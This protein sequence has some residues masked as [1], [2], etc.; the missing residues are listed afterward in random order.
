MRNILLLLSL[1]IF[2][3]S[4]NTSNEAESPVN[5]V[6]PFIGTG[7][8]GH[9]YPGASLPFGM[10]QLS[11][12][13]RL[14]GW[15]GCSAYHY[16]DSIVYG[17]SH[18]H[19]SGTGIP[20]YGDVLFMPTVGAIQW[21]NGYKTGVDNGYASRFDHSKEVAEAGYYSVDLLDYNIGVELTVTKRAG[22]HRYKFP[23]SSQSN[24]IL[25]L[26]HRD[27]LLDADIEILNHTTLQGKR[28]SKEWAQQQQLYFY[29]EFSKPFENSQLYQNELIELDGASRNTKAAFS[30][31]TEAGEEILIRIGIS[32]VSTEGARKN[33]EAEIAHWDFDKTRSEAQEA[34]NEAL[35][36][37][38]IKGGSEDQKTI[39][40]TALYHTMLSPNL[41]MDVDGS[42]LG[43]DFKTHK[44]EGF[45]NYTVF[46][47]WDT[48]RAA[49]PL[50]TLIERD[51][52]LDFIQTF[53]NQ[54]K[55]GGQLPVWE[56]AA[57]YTG[58]MIGY[59][60]VSVI[61]DAYA[62]GITDFDTALAL[63]AMKH[64]ANKDHLGLDAYK[65]LGY[66][67][68][69][70]EPES[71]SK[72]LEYAYDDWC[73][74]QFAKATGA[75]EDYFNFQRRSQHYK[76]IFDPTEGFM[77]AKMYNTWFAPFDPAEVNFNYTEA[78]SWQYS[79]CVQ[80]DIP[81]MIALY[82]GND[83]FEAK[84][85]QLFET[86]MELSGREQA[87]ITGLIGQ[88]A[89]G[90]E[91]SHHMAY[92]YNYIGK[93]WK[94]QERVRKILRTMYHNLP[95]GLS[96]NE[97]CGQM[98]AWY[99]LSAMGFYSVTPGSPFYALGTPIF[100]EVS[101]HLENGKTF[102]IKADNLSEK[103]LYIQSASLNGVTLT[104]AFL[105]HSS[106]LEG[107][108]LTLKMG[109]AANKDWGSGMT[110]IEEKQPVSITPVPF[111]LSDSRTFIDELEIQLQS[112]DPDSKIYYSLDG[113]P[114]TNG[115]EL[116]QGPI[117]LKE[118]T[119]ITA[120]AINEGRSSATIRSEFFKIDGGRSIELKSSYANQYAAGGPNALIDYMKGTNNYRT[121]AWQGYEGQD[122]AAVVDLGEIKSPA[123]VSMGFVQDIK[124]WIWFPKE[125]TFEISKDGQKFKTV[126]VV[127]NDFSDKEY[128]AFTKQFSTEVHEP[129]RFLRVTAVNFG[130]CPDWHLGAGGNSWIFTDE[131]DIR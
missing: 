56:L 74:A 3:I 50:Y 27:R 29:A 88:Y 79:F 30:F 36:K 106:I 49:H 123:Q 125:V 111:I 101:I 26:D 38:T 15:D 78:N 83:K 126:A 110:S 100:D 44:A 114:V 90:N 14:E 20:D 87:D 96:G 7:G 94:T 124:S 46:S 85:D 76:N 130:K 37:I 13:T 91:P 62:K 82:G 70:H 59:H 61:A 12:D 33:L 113:K 80:Q 25:D 112:V 54:Y 47:L 42:Y 127:P 10:M 92:L 17:F 34:W 40:Y 60:S 22:L 73:I 64:S 43:T 75:E 89:H 122:V 45:N 4:C 48:Y 28:F 63:E 51:R 116:Y 86:E 105:S 119:T 32:A 52:T 103:N 1:A 67:P 102:T 57:N 121:G 55:N 71:V 104:E 35:N 107:G 5:Y 18:T 21:D 68:A 23:A 72:T 41:F 129:F 109:A 31:N 128:G 95:D 66:I 118:S 131:I 120:M 19:L 108:T 6:N 115:A 9:T 11:P 58:C 77:R 97:D 39:F 81:G 8:H 98:S 93:P 16:T 53:L 84:L 24:V 99:V 65:S 117:L 69:D 2:I